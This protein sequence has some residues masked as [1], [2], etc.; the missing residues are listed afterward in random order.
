MTSRYRI[1]VLKVAWASHTRRGPILVHTKRKDLRDL[2]REQAMYLQIAAGGYY[3]NPK[4]SMSPRSVN[5]GNVYRYALFDGHN[6][7]VILPL[8][9]SRHGRSDR[10]D[11]TSIV[12]LTISS[13]QPD[14]ATGRSKR[15]L[16]YH[17]RVR[18]AVDPGS[19]NGSEASNHDLK[20]TGLS[21]SHSR[22]LCR[23]DSNSDSSP[24]DSLSS[25]F[26]SKNLCNHTDPKHQRTQKAFATTTTCLPT[27]YETFHQ[28]TASRTQHSNNTKP[29]R[30]SLNSQ[31][32]LG[33][34]SQQE[35]GTDTMGHLKFQHGIS[36]A[37]RPPSTPIAIKKAAM[38]PQAE[39]EQAAL[40]NAKREYEW[41]TWRLYDRIISHRQ[42]HQELY[43]R[44]AESNE[45]FFDE[46]VGESSHTQEADFQGLA[47][48]T[49]NSITEE[50]IFE[51]DL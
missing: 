7:G 10:L 24:S 5:S 1:P 48:S 38:N 18:R 49:T 32:R 15:D 16:S 20:A 46:H 36:I 35:Q 19:N 6:Q 34:D 30:S 3:K 4:E 31:P 37:R 23:T 26:L 51:M 21:V 17:N 47:D 22:F 14:E 27:H 25:P 41:A 42:K 45:G 2:L 43:E 11:E 39:A 8:D 12:P 29:T 13:S 9:P 50:G 44:I 40:A 28:E 33:I